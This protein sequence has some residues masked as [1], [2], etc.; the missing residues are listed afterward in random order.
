MQGLVP[1]N[2]QFSS[3]S[4]HYSNMQLKVEGGTHP[5]LK[6]NEKARRELLNLTSNPLAF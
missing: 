4:N 2:H 6:L 3:Y 1:S 5:S